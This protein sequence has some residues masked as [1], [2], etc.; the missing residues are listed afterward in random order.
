MN[1]SNLVQE[2][3]TVA[4]AYRNYNGGYFKTLIS[5]G[6]S[7][8]GLAALD[9]VL[10]RGAEPPLHVHEKE[11]ETFYILEGAVRFV[12]DGTPHMLETGSALFAPRGIPHYFEILTETVRILTLLT[13]GDFWNYF[14]EFSE[15]CHEAPQV[16]APVLPTPEQIR[17]MAERLSNRY[18]LGLII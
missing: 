10:P 7:G 13:P 16:T 8:G 12:I 5:P 1:V 6:Q 18:H 3:T 4:P 11:D 2:E 14:M 17:H 15:P 9:M